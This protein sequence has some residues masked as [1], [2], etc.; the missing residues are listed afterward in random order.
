MPVIDFDP[1]ERFV[2]DTVGPPG[3]RVFFLQA[4]QGSRVMTVSLEKDQVRLLGRSIAEMLDQVAPEEGSEAAGEAVADNAPLDTPIEED[5]RVR[6]LSMAWDAGRHVVVVEAHDT[7]PDEDGDDESLPDAESTAALHG[8]R[9]V[10]S[11]AQARAFSVRCA[12]AVAG[13]RP[14][15]PFCGGPLD[16]SGHI[17]PRANG[18]RR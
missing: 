16:P 13:G 7:D 14:N 18:Y 2:T 3:Q 12:R 6:R 4:T 17:C 15:C 10:L 9:V 11:P 8:L 5:F 1:P